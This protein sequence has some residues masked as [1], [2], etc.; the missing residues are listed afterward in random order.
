[1]LALYL[2]VW[3]FGEQL[4]AKVTINKLIPGSM[5]VNKSTDTRDNVSYEITNYTL[6]PEGD[7]LK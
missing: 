2:T 7:I 3:V 6:I 5:L 1:M 4:P